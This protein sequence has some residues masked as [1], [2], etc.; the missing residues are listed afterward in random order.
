MFA[1]AR[2]RPKAAE[3]DCET[4]SS[5]AMNISSILISTQSCIDPRV[6]SERCIT[7]SI[8]NQ[9][10]GGVSHACSLHIETNLGMLNI[11]FL[12]LEV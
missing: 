6:E 8:Y 3:N 4:I 12:P 10:S 2:R 7:T 5:V 1:P 9:V 11:E